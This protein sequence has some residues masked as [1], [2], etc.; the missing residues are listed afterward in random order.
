MEITGYKWNMASNM[1]HYLDLFKYLNNFKKIVSSEVSLNKKIFNSKHHGY[2]EI[3]G[4]INL[5]TERKNII[6]FNDTKKKEI[7]GVKIKVFNKEKKFIINEN[8]QLIFYKGKKTKFIIPFQ[9]NLT[10]KYAYQIFS[11]GRCDLPSL[12]ESS[13]LHIIIIKI[14][15]KFTIYRNKKKLF[16][17]T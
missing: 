2:K 13:Y 1:I 3:R 17:F 10:N 11:R 9:S 7:N 8:K 12:Q 15:N 14:L 16:P 4:N 5:F 6:S